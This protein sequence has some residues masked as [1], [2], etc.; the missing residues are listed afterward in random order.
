MLILCLCDKSLRECQHCRNLGRIEPVNDTQFFRKN[1]KVFKKFQKRQAL[2]YFT[3]IPESVYNASK[4]CFVNNIGHV[5]EICSFSISYRA[6]HLCLFPTSG[7]LQRFKC[8]NARSICKSLK[9]GL[10]LLRKPFPVFLKV[11]L[12]FSKQTDV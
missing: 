2:N 8:L 6:Q 3:L 4:L 7:R 1:K 10:S 5:D 9:Q 12:R 11:N